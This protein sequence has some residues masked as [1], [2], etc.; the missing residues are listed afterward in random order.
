MTVAAVH[1]VA[2]Q[3]RRVVTGTYGAVTIDAGGTY[4]YTLD[5]SDSI[6]T[7]WRRTP[8]STDV[9]TYT[10]TD[11]VGATST[12]N[13]TITITGTNDAPVAIGDAN[14]DDAVTEAGVN[15]APPR[16]RRPRPRRGNVLTNDTDVDTGAR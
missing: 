12:A 16:S 15:P 8:R 1:G 2:L 3:R 4:T 14:A 5:N 7:R 13:L 6:P 9:F 11:T 10:V